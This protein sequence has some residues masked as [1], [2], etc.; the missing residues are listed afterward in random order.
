MRI[1]R[2]F[3]AAII[4]VFALDAFLAAGAYAALEFKETGMGFLVGK[5]LGNQVFTVKAGSVTCTELEIEKVAGSE[6][7]LNAE[8]QL[9]AVRYAGCTTKGFFSV[10]VRPFTIM[11]DFNI[12]GEVRIEGETIVEDEGVN[13]KVRIP[14]QRLTAVEYVNKAGKVEIVAKIAK[15]STSGEGLSVCTYASEANGTYNGSS[16]VELPGFEIS[17]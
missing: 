8:F 5:G 4:A 3:M 15:V 11:Y 1:M 14:G 16:L 10:K 12:N 13:C 17:A 6:A 9:A 7:E 2:A